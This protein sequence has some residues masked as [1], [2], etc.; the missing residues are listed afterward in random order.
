[1]L[2]LI[3]MK[4]MTSMEI[5]HVL[6]SLQAFVGRELTKVLF[7]EK[8]LQLSL[9]GP[10]GYGWVT[11]SLKPQTYF[12]VSDSKIPPIKGLK[13]PLVLF[14]QTHLKGRSLVSCRRLEEQG[15]V[16]QMNFSDCGNYFLRV[17]LFP[18][19]QNIEVYAGAKSMTAFKPRDLV[20]HKAE[21]SQEAQYRR[22]E[23]FIEHWL[24][25]KP[26]TK[27]QKALPEND[28]QKA[29]KKKK[30]GLIKMEESL[31]KL[32]ES[33]WSELGEW[34]KA[35][36]DLSDVP[37]DWGTLVDQTKTLSWNIE[38]SFSQMKKVKIKI[39][40]TE[41]RMSLLKIEIEKMEKGDWERPS[42]SSQSLMHISDAKG[43]TRKLSDGSSFYVG[44]SGKDNLALLRRAKPWFLWLHIRDY[45]GAHGILERQ[46]KAGEPSLK[47][48]QEAAVEVLKQTLKGPPEGA[49]EVLIAECRYVRPI[50]GGK[51]GQVTH[52][53]EK[54]LKIT[55]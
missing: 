31:I 26:K 28:L 54:V 15:R 9:S 8:V 55:L 29:L 1:M 5:D 7:D 24:S 19:G 43:R 44:K 12:F 11:F 52:S 45:P 16:V 49:Y 38:N 48:L 21:Q 3:I 40:G 36:K 14:C 51:P 37:Q 22:N 6:K 20:P 34:L 39:L 42:P 53:H 50:K 25:S 30:R 41:D 23:D 17:A 27:P 32:K 10:E 46:K 33:P 13:K 2:S 18:G 4:S 47:I 35:Q